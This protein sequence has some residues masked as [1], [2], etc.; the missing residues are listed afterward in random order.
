VW[1]LPNP[2]GAYIA[3][4]TGGR[5]NAFHKAKA[6]VSSIKPAQ[7]HGAIPVVVVD[8]LRDMLHTHPA[9]ERLRR[10]LIEEF[11]SWSAKIP[12]IIA[13][14]RVIE[15]S[16]SKLPTGIVE[17][18]WSQHD[19]ECRA[20]EDPILAMPRGPRVRVQTSS[21]SRTGRNLAESGKSQERGRTCEYLAFKWLCSLYPH[22]D[23]DQ[24][25]SEWEVRIRKH[26]GQTAVVK[27]L[28]GADEAG[29]HWDISELDG[30]SGML[31]RCYEIKAPAARLTQAE[32]KCAQSVGVDYFVV[33]VDP[34]SGLIESATKVNDLVVTT[35]AVP[36]VETGPAT[37]K[38]PQPQLREASPVVA[39]GR[40]SAGGWFWGTGRRKA[41]VAR[42]RVRAGSGMFQVNGRELE[43]YFTQERDHKDIVAV[44]EA[45]NTLGDLEVQVKVHGGGYSGQAGAIRLGLGRS[46][47]R[48]DGSLEQTLRDHGFLTRDPRRVE[49]K[50]PGQPGARKRFQFSK[51]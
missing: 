45:T 37:Q 39:M 24:T 5:L 23:S 42:V 7:G 36:N 49:R 4:S 11:E 13:D 15:R 50:K 34:D 3:F 9:A 28:N 32:D 17:Q 43:E 48:Y 51:R 12:P 29:C 14:G 18:V 16:P 47:M 20:A 27:W 26:S 19:K 38:E 1:G 6:A 21:S 22:Q 35:E 41:A 25:D 40:P 10:K 33:R 8:V 46:L 2:Y 31:T 44:L 30:V